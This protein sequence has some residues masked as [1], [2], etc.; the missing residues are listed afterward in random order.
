MDETKYHPNYFKEYYLN[1]KKRFLQRYHDNKQKKLNEI[2]NALPKNY[3]FDK[4][5]ELG[6]I[7]VNKLDM[8]TYEEVFEKIGYSLN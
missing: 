4:L 7:K 5:L 2:E 6:Y 1:N 8:K 3:Y